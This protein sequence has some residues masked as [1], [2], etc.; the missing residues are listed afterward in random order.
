MAPSEPGTAARENTYTQSA[1]CLC[2]R[3]IFRRGLGRWWHTNGIKDHM[4]TP[5]RLWLKEGD[6][7]R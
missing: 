3:Q 4:A 6:D 5:Q 1:R 7:E 2:G